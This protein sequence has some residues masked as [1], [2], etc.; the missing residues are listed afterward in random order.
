V[1]QDGIPVRELAKLAPAG[2]PVYKGM[3]RWGYIT[4]KP[5]DGDP[6][7]RPPKRDLIVGPSQAGLAAAALWRGLPDEIERRW[8]ARLADAAIDELGGALSD[9]VDQFP[10]ELPRFLPWLGYPQRSRLHA[11]PQV[12]RQA[13]GPAFAGGLELPA[14]LSRALLVFAVDYEAGAEVPLPL[15]ANVLRVLT[16]EGVR[17]RDLPGRAGVAREWMATMTGRLAKA[18]VVAVVEDPGAARGKLVRL[19]ELGARGL[20]E[21]ARRTAEVER[22]WAA[23]YGED[24]VAALRAALDPLAAGEEPPLFAGLHGNRDGWRAKAP[25]RQAL[26]HYPVMRLGGFPDAA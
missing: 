24:E 1:P 13:P 21:Y 15:A 19:T 6:R 17:V 25:P 7:R 18:G 10:D 3:R 2:E 9:V 20:D 11:R 16:R 5:A 8:R 23:R 26:P 14:L 22:E 4:I 12:V